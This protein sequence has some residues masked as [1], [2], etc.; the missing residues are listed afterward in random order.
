MVS[1][2]LLAIGALITVACSSPLVE[3]DS[4]KLNNRYIIKLKGEADSNQAY[5]GTFSE[6]LVSE[7]S[8]HAD[9]DYIEPE[10]EFTILESQANP[11]SWGLSRISQRASN[12]TAPYTYPSSAGEGVDV[13]ILDTGIYTA[14]KDFEGRASQ[15][16]SFI[17]GEAAEDLNGHGTHV[18]G[19]VGGK[20]FGVAKKVKLI[21]V[22]VLSGQGSGSTAGVIAGINWVAEQAKSTGRKSIAN[23]SLGGGK[24]PAIVEAVEAAVKSGVSFIV[25]AGN[26]S[27]DAC[28]VSPANAP[29]AFAVGS[30]NSD[31]SRR[32]NSNWGACVKLSAPGTDIVSASIDGVNA[33]RKNSGTSMAS[34][35]VAG[36]AALMLAEGLVST[37]QQIYDALLSAATKNVLTDLKGATP[38]LLL[39]NP[40]A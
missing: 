15:P 22:K 30:T 2:R 35:H 16:V 6:D 27:Q 5:A 3:G 13:Y 17:E 28:N 20:L 9:I 8:S 33:S 29:S 11:P 23:V 37:P 32:F 21:G 12:L 24:S 19:T 40:L 38:N 25:A 1:F 18:A 26:E 39:F 36:V 4:N 7:L 34:P 10:Q 31:D 14:H